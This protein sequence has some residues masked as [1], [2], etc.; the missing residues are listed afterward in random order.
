MDVSPALIAVAR[1]QRILNADFSVVSVLE[2][3]FFRT[4][5][6][7]AVVCSG[8]LQIFDDISIPIGNLL[9]T[10]A[11]HG[12]AHFLAPVNDDP[13]D[14]LVR[15]RDNREHSEGRM[16][17][18]QS[19]WNIFCKETFE[20]VIKGHAPSMH[21]EWRDFA[22][23]FAISKSDDPMRSWTIATERSPYQTVNGACQLLNLKFLSVLPR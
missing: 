21:C 23:P 18:W 13:I 1:H 22:M 3:D 17:D 5:M 16:H 14:V 8:V 19:G 4:G 2:P 20:R 10:V 15:Y 9:R 11:P 12:E 6:F 7:D